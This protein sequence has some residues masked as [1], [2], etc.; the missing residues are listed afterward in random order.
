MNEPDRAPAGAAGTLLLQVLLGL[1]PDRGR[2][3]SRRWPRSTA[4]GTC[5]SRTH[6]SPSKRR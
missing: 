1:R 5:A 4:S 6:T 2:H 3:A